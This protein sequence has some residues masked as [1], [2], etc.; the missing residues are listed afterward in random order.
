MGL[1][2]A[3]VPVI[4]AASIVSFVLGGGLVGLVMS[5]A[6]VKPEQAA[7]PPPAEENNDAKGSKGGPPGMGGAKG[8]PPGMGGA[9]GGFGG[10]GAKGGPPGGGFGGGGQRGPTS[11]AQLTQL[12]SKLDTLTKKPLTVSLDAEQKKQAVAI[13][14]EIGTKE[15]LTEDEA[16]KQLDALLKIVEGNKESLEAAGFRWPG[17][18]GGGAPP[19]GV[20][21]PANPFKAG[22]AETQLK[23]LQGTLGK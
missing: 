16:K 13:L 11:K 12:V 22:D 17:S 1:M 7:A 19:L 18:V 5:Y 23:S 2:T 9:K 3:K 14:A 21:P 10:G 20:T 15:E 8:G 4:V 6:V